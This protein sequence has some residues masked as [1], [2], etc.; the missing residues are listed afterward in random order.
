LG[1]WRGAGRCRNGRGWF[2]GDGIWEKQTV[3]FSPLLEGEGTKPIVETRDHGRG[4]FSTNHQRQRYTK[5]DCNLKLTVRRERWRERERE[6]E[7][8]GEREK[9]KEGEREKRE[10][11]SKTKTPKSEPNSALRQ[12]AVKGVRFPQCLVMMQTRIAMQSNFFMKKNIL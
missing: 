8:D 5:H 4:E 2:G 1:V 3:R 6:G 7:S 10:K 9:E 12:I 11:T